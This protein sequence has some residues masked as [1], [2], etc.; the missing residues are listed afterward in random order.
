[1]LKESNRRGFNGIVL[2]IENE[3][4][5]SISSVLCTSNLRL[6]TIIKDVQAEDKM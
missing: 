1:M 3:E 5:A 2:L 6:K 4:V